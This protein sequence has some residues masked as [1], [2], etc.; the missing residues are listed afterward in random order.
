MRMVSAMMEKWTKL[1]K[2]KERKSD[3]PEVRSLKFP[4]VLL[5]LSS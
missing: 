3:I 2:M 5:P 1:S 4:L